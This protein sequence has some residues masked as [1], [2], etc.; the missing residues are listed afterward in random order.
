MGWVQ[1]AWFLPPP[2]RR[3]QVK[4][5]LD[6]AQCNSPS[7]RCDWLAALNQATHNPGVNWGA[8]PTLNVFFC[9]RKSFGSGTTVWGPSPMILGEDVLECPPQ[10]V[11][12]RVLFPIC[13]LS[14]QIIKHLQY[15]WA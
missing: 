7:R 13:W 15:D 9:E 14:F 12:S 1:G 5:E 4:L 2:C 3:P 10:I 11:F 8:P 6:C